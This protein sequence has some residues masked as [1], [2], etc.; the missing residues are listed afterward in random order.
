MPFLS[1]LSF[2]SSFGSPAKFTTEGKKCSRAL[3]EEYTRGPL[4]HRNKTDRRHAFRHNADLYG[5]SSSWGGAKILLRLPQFFHTKA[6]FIFAKF[7]RYIQ[8]RQLRKKR[9]SFFLPCAFGVFFAIPT[10]LICLLATLQGKRGEMS[11]YARKDGG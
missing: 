11:D 5:L 2:P 4:S 1:N 3:L 9:A 6:L 10:G 7:R 8:I